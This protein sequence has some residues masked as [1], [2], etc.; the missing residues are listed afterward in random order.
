MC[1]GCYEKQLKIDRLE[2]E[3]L[4]LKHKLRYEKRKLKDG[5]FG[6]STPSSKKLFKVNSNE[7][8]KDDRGAKKGHKG[9][10]RSS[11]SKDTAQEIE[12]IN[13]PGRCPHCSSKLQS[14]GIINRSVIK[15][16]QAGIKKVLYLCEKK[17]CPRCKK[18]II[19]KAPVLPRSLYGNGLL[20]NT[21]VWHYIHGIPLGRIEDI[22]RC[23]IS[24]GSLY[25]SFHR[26]ARLWKPAIPKVIKDY[27]RSVVKHADETGWRNDGDSGYA[28]IFCTKAI[29]IFQFSESRSS[30][31]AQNIF[32]KKRLPGFLVVDRY[33][34]YNK[35]PCELQYCYSHLLRKV[36]D[37]GAQFIDEPEVQNFVSIFIP[38]LSQAMHLRTL[39]ISNKVYYRRAR[40]LKR[41]I[42]KVVNAPASHGRIKEIQRIFK[43][44]EN[45]LY[46]WCKNRQVPAENNRAE[47]ELRPTVIARKISFGSQSTQGAMTRSILMT[48]LHTA[49]KRLKNQSLEEWFRQSLD[50]IAAEPHIAPYSLLPPHDLTK[51][52]NN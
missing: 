50:K 1:P 48:I 36:E 4:H 18:T 44:N 27:R 13:G 29:S 6:S 47:R 19:S 2:E 45:R 43:E 40:R 17:W 23:S 14:K 38:L 12:R 7:R 41:D 22:L 34:V 46:H 20:A 3:V 49:K 33:A 21:A 26:L 37:M 25:E 15:G 9:N 51:T 24:Q 8:L 11:I 35:S 30:K 32:G 5:Y 52:P 10:G 31:I 28:W 16:I 39:S 42:L